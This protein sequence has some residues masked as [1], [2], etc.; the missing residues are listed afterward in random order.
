MATF[1]LTHVGVGL[2]GATAA[3]HDC[4][5]GGSD[6]WQADIDGIR[7]LKHAG[8]AVT[9]M[10]TVSSKNFKVARM[11]RW[12]QHHWGSRRRV[13][14]PLSVHVRRCTLMYLFISL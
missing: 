11:Y 12:H 4:L 6:A 1:P 3:T 13:S 9:V 7:R 8:V 14:E 5:R 2:E 10:T